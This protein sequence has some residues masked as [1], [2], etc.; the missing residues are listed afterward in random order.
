[1]PT[2]IAW[3]GRAAFLEMLSQRP[4]DT[5]TIELYDAPIDQLRDL[6]EL[7]VQ[8]RVPRFNL[9][10]H[11]SYT[12]EAVIRVP[13]G[14]NSDAICR[15]S[16]SLWAVLANL[17]FDDFI[18]WYGGAAITSPDGRYTAEPDT[19]FLPTSRGANPGT[20]FPSV[21]V[22]VGMTQS[23]PSLRRVVRGWFEMSGGLA[24]IVILVDIRCR[25][26]GRHEVV[27]EK[28]RYPGGRPVCDTEVSVVLRPDFQD[29]GVPFDYMP[30]DF[31]ATT[32]PESAPLPMT[33][34][35]DLVCDRAPGPGEGDI[36]LPALFFQ[37]VAC[38]VWRSFCAPST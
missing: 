14:P 3:P 6:M 1:M 9:L 35:F 2:P 10:F 26:S 11:D 27:F 25:L 33:L 16:C 29:P 31:T 18:E 8:R 15:I 30:A 22:E 21:M 17:G 34:E 37:D 12:G 7:A 19:S 4:L 24:K 32:T 38:R 23:R 13:S 20:R 36:L 28:W 5:D